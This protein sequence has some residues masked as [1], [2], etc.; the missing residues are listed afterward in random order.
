MR[1]NFSLLLAASTG[2]GLTPEALAVASGEP[3]DGLP[4]DSEKSFAK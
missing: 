3:Q 4:R 1:L 2:V